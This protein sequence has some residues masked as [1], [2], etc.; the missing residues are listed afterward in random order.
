MRLFKKIAVSVHTRIDDLATQ[1]ENKEGLS[2]SYIR[3]YE[4]HAAKAKVKLAQVRADVARLDK[5][6]RQ[7]DREKT[8]WTDRA[9]RIYAADENKALE[10]VRRLKHVQAAKDQLRLDWSQARDLESR[11]AGD[12]DQILV[13]LD[14]LKRKHRALSGRQACAEALDS[15]QGAESKVGQDVDDLFERWDM[16]VTARELHAQCADTSY[17]CLADEFDREEEAEDLRA[18]LDEIIAAKPEK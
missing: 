4:R 17:D 18:A 13:K 3:E 5:R 14:E 7:L 12:V 1:F 15:F 8:L 16:D 10:C 2:A 11:M 6:A 9:K